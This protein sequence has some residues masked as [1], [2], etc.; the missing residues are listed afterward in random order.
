MVVLHRVGLI[1]NI[2]LGSRR[3]SLISFSKFPNTK[4]QKGRVTSSPT[5]KPTCGKCGKKHYGDSL[6][7]TDI[8]L[9]V[10]S[11]HTRL[12]ISK[13]EAATKR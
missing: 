4:S 9:G 3:G 11:V 8:S 12:V 7:R 13:C 1:S 10:T 2:I 6:V 5:K